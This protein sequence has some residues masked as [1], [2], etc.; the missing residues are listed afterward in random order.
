MLLLDA[1]DEMGTAATG[2]SIEDQFR[3]L[4]KPT[5]EAMSKTGNRVLITC[6]SHIYVKDA[7]HGNAD[8]LIHRD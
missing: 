8:N 3:L 2:R 6:R 7:C 1:F 5:Q 4:A